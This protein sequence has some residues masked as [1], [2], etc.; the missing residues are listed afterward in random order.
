MITENDILTLTEIAGYLKVS[1]KTVVRMVKAGE[2]PGAK[3]ANQWRFARAAIDDWLNSRMYNL[4]KEKLVNV[5]ATADHVIPLLELVSRERIVM[6]LVPTPKEDV[7]R[8]LARPLLDTGVIQDLDRYTAL[9]CEREE[10]L[11]TAIGHGLAIPHIRDPQESEAS[12][13]SIVIGICREGMDFGAL[14]EL[15]TRVFA[16][17]CSN[18]D[19]SHL[20][21]VAKIS[22]IFRTQGVLERMTAAGNEDEILAILRSADSD[23]SSLL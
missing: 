20:R 3:V 8:A 15:K 16:L 22:L 23:L 5:V 17:P 9:L 18:T 2:L 11:S 19:A 1:E 12:G 6:D 4:P 7:L 21:L 14:D 13:P 10:L